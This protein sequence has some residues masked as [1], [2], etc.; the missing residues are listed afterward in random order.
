MFGTLG[1]ENAHVLQIERSAMSR[2][3][4]LEPED[5]G[6]VVRA[7]ASSGVELLSEVGL[8]LLYGERGPPVPSVKKVDSRKR[9]LSSSII[10]I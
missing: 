9:K 1:T 8:S 3:E 5:E 7:E 10:S 4:V 2:S 6:N